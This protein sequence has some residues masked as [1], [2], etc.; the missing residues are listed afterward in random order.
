MHVPGYAWLLPVRFE[1]RAHPEV[2][3]PVEGADQ[4]HPV[5]AKSELILLLVGGLSPDPLE[6]DEIA[7]GS[8]GKVARFPVACIIHRSG[9]TAVTRLPQCHPAGVLTTRYY[10]TPVAGYIRRLGTSGQ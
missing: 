10:P 5:R 8:P 2:S 1:V 7:F 3:E 9:N 6:L 4:L